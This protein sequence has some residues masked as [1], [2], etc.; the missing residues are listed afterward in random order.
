MLVKQELALDQA[1][2]QA[3]K[4]YWQIRKAPDTRTGASSSRDAERTGNQAEASE[5]EKIRKNIRIKHRTSHPPT[6]HEI[7]VAHKKQ[8]QE[9]IGEGS[10]PGIHFSH[11][12]GFEI[13]IPLELL[14]LNKTN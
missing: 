12:K 6:S 7:R 10:E 14:N 11:K 3:C 8:L 1:N 9:G 2:E 4:D 13:Y 5:E